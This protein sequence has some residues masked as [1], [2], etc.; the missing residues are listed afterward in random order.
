[1]DI[2]PADRHVGEAERSVKTVKER[3]RSTV[4][5]FPFKRIPKLLVVHIVADAVRCL[6]QFP[7]RNGVSRDASPLSIV[8]G[9]ATPDYNCMRVELGQYVQV[10]EPS[11]HTNTPKSRSLGAIALT[12]TGNTN[13]DYYFLSLA[14]GARISLHQWTVI[15]I[16]DTCIARVEA[17]AKNERQP[18]IQARGLVVEWRPG[19][20]VDYDAYDF[21][22]DADAPN[23]AQ[24]D[25]PL[26]PAD[27]DPIVPAEL[28]D[29]AAPEDAASQSAIL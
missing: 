28:A 26:D 29:L 25:D 8:T 15:P 22:Y 14:T 13:G 10:F 9:A 17:L 6:N 3:L 23:A 27:Y 5:G 12:P 18:L 2:V 4:H 16:T 19:H 7:W 21:N 1:M 11:D 24:I 20:L